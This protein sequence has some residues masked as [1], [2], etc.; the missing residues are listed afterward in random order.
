MIRVNLSKNG[1]LQGEGAGLCEA[2][3]QLATTQPPKAISPGQASCL[4]LA[5]PSV[6][7]SYAAV[8]NLHKLNTLKQHRFIILQ[9][10]KAEL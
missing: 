7:V 5:T 4:D 2:M 6:L 3:W 1:H 10:W 9:F 8:T